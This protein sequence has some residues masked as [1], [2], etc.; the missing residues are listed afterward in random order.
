MKQAAKQIIRFGNRDTTDVTP[1]WPVWER[2][3]WAN[4]LWAGPMVT[5]THTA[6]R[7]AGCSRS[8]T[9]TRRTTPPPTR[10]RS[11][12]TRWSSTGDSNGRATIPFSLTF[13]HEAAHHAGFETEAEADTLELCAT[14]NI[15]KEDSIWEEKEKQE[16]DVRIPVSPALIRP[17]W[18][19][20]PGV[21][22]GLGS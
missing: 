8:L 22:A 16:K 3:Y 11:R 2:I 7:T 12:Y 19:R 20:P 18:W 17:T 14:R 6:P 13:N 4:Q 9:S 10:P 15:P 21:E 5:G 1:M